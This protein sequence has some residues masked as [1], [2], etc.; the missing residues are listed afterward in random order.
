[1]SHWKDQLLHLEMEPPSNA[2]RR[3]EQ[4]RK[5]NHW[6]KW[7]VFM[8]LFAIVV[9]SAYQ[10]YLPENKLTSEVSD[11]YSAQ[12]PSPAV[13]PNAS[14]SSEK[15]SETKTRPSANTAIEIPASEHLQPSSP[16]TA[17]PYNG[18]V[19]SKQ[20]ENAGHIEFPT[21]PA[22]FQEASPMIPIGEDISPVEESAANFQEDPS[23]PSALEDIAFPNVFTPNGD[24]WN[25]EFAPQSN[26]PENYSIVQWELLRNGQLVQTFSEYLIWNGQD[27][28]GDLMSA[29]EY[30]F[31][32]KIKNELGNYHD[33]WGT[34]RLQ[35]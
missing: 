13:T 5:W 7:G 12:I 19:I 4:K 22:D 8:A 14:L 31:H 25:D 6:G 24:G 11:V 3:I 16:S 33:Q 17:F 32:L 18:R 27:P 34:I 35:R 2:W 20:T 1:M 9:I 23:S 21:S 29:G 28:A 15:S 26:L 30:Q 10:Y